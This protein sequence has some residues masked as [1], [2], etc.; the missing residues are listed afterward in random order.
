M[1]PELLTRTYN[2]YMIR[3]DWLD[4]AGVKMP[5]TTDELAA[6]LKAFQDKD[7]NGSGKKDEYWSATGMDK[8]ILPIDTLLWPFGATAGNGGFAQEGGKAVYS[9]LK[10]E[11]KEGIS[12]LAKLYSE[13]LLDPEYMINDDTKLQQKYATE[14]IAGSYASAA[15]VVNWTNKITSKNPNAKLVP[16]PSLKGPSG[17]GYWYESNTVNVTNPGICLAITSANKHVAETMLWQDWVYTKEGNMAFNF[18]KEGDTYTIV[19]GQPQFTEKITKDSKGRSQNEMIGITATAQTMWPTLGDLTA[20]KIQKT[21]T[22]WNAFDIWGKNMPDNSRIMPPI[23]F[24]DA[25]LAVMTSKKAAIDDYQKQMLDKFIMGKEPIENYDK[26]FVPKLKQ[27]GIDDVL[28]AY[29]GALDRYN[30]R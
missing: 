18:G 20:T 9:P 15:R 28:K 6:V 27:L 10:P 26:V 11:Y 3:Q 5:T 7:V 25:E 2:G 1:M 29:Q 12:Y 8:G 24:N 21:S 13:G 14:N 30:K 16:I 23:T 19:N 22:E 17:K 4:K